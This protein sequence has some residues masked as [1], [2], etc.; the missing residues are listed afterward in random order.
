MKNLLIIITLLTPSCSFHHYGADIRESITRYNRATPFIS[1]GDDKKTA[2]E[3][4]Y[5]CQEDLADKFK[6][7]PESFIDKDGNVIEIHYALSRF[8]HDGVK[9]DDEYTPYVFKNNTLTAIGWTA[10]GGPR[11]VGDTPRPSIKIQQDLTIRTDEES[12]Y[13]PFGQH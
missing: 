2:I 6:K 10:L 4:L 11:T 12:G 3:R 13:K 8:I 1:V 7:N 5:I 9:T